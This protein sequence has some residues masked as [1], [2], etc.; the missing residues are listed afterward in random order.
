MLNPVLRSICSIKSTEARFS[1]NPDELYGIVMGL[2]E[3]TTHVI[4]E[5]VQKIPALLDDGSST[6]GRNE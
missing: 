4:I 5:E 2:P 6:D 1:R 3:A